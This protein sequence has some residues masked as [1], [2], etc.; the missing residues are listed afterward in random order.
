M[1]VGHR[2]GYALGMSSEEQYKDVRFVIRTEQ[3]SY[4]SWVGWAEIGE[5]PPGKRL[6][7]DLSEIDPRCWKE[8]VEE[9]QAVE[10]ARSNAHR[11]IDEY[12][13]SRAYDSNSAI[14]QT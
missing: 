8:Y 2:L 12:L 1:C 3:T 10:S 6:I 13:R 11:F 14:S 7:T 4:G 9:L 5:Q